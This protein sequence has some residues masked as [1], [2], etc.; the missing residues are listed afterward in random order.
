MS[1]V[2]EQSKTVTFVSLHFPEKQ[3]KSRQKNVEILEASGL[4][5]KENVGRPEKT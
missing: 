5:A 2:P 3:I 1:G 4:G